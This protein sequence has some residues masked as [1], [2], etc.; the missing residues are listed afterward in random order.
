[1]RAVKIEYV[2]PEDYDALYPPQELTVVGT[3]PAGGGSTV[4]WADVTGK[5][6]TFVPTVG[7]TAT[8][9]KAGNYT[10]TSAEVAT[11]LKAKTQVAALA[12]VSAANGAPAAADPVTKAEYDVLVTLANAN[13]AAI[14]AIITALKA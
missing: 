13:K 1:M 4:A 2:A 8:T 5:P 3:D 6:A 9:A 14:N 7:T 12:A 10:P 11:A